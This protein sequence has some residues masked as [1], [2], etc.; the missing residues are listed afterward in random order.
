MFVRGSVIEFM[1][2]NK[3]LS[4]V[5]ERLDKVFPLPTEWIPTY[6]EP[7]YDLDIRREEIKQFIKAEFNSYF[8]ARLEE[9]LPELFTLYDD[10][11]EDFIRGFNQAIKRT[12]QRAKL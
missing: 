10:D 4:A 11:N 8:T 6:E 1:T 5:L 7:I 2:K 12:K 9:V 3:Q